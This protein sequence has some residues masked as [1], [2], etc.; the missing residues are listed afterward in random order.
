MAK[1]KGLIFDLN[2]TIINDMPI[3]REVWFEILNNKLKA[4][5]TQEE[6][7]ANMY[8]K[9][10]ELLERIFGKGKFTQEELISISLQKEAIYQE[11]YKDKIKAIDG[12]MELIEKATSENLSLAITSAANS[13]NISYIVDNLSIRHYFKVII[14]ADDVLMSKPHP[15]PFIKT[16]SLLGLDGEECIV[17]EDS[18]FGVKSAKDAGIKSIALLTTHSQEEFEF[19]NDSVLMY[20][21]DYSSA[22]LELIF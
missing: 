5:L 6:V 8:G 14:S 3:H 18:P 20:A 17:F 15:E 21:K 11:V 13:N 1:Y 4:G 2:G 12:F 16:L 9:N 7:N 19:V 22:V 10:E